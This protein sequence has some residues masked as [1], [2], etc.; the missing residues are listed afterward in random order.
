MGCQQAQTVREYFRDPS[1]HEAYLLGL[2]Q[3]GLGGTALV[4]RWLEAATSALS[5]AL[6]VQAPFRE[7]GIFLAEEPMALGFRLSLRRGQRLEVE[8]EVE[9]EEAVRVFID[10]FRAAPEP[11]RMPARVTSAAPGERRLTYEPWAEGV[12]VARV[13]PELLRRGRYS[14][15]IR[16]GGALAF[17]VE[18]FDTR[19]IGSVFGDPREGGRR[20]HHGVDIFAPR[21]TPALAAAEA[22]VSRV[23]DGG[24]GG[25]TVWLRDTARGNSLYYAHLDR[26]LVEEGD[27]LMPGDTV[28]LVGNTGNARTT[29]PHLHFGIYRRRHGPLDPFPFLW[30]PPGELPERVADASFLGTWVRIRRGDI[31]LREA[32]ST[33]APTL[34]SMAVNTTLRV[35]AASGDWYRVRLPD[36]RGG[37]VLARLT[38]PLTAPLRTARATS[39]VPVRSDPRGDALVLHQVGEGSAIEVL[40]EFRDYLYVRPPQGPPGWVAV[41]P[42]G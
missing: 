28:G 24:L 40:G 22:T 42:E 26:Q 32:P 19:A 21:G 7:E 31:R 13:Q 29:P 18:G 30:Q 9:A 27:R 3:S 33:R 35:V 23:R 41:T 37:F 8:L 1:P 39:D 20:E 12:Y 38:E 2:T 5:E 36:G 14:L 11:T 10:L 25:K 17:P 6:T 34:D 15:T 16:A 4:E